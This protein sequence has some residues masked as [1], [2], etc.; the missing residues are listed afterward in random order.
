MNNSNKTLLNTLSFVALAIIALLILL[1]NIL[2]LLGVTIGGPVINA[3]ETVKNILILIVIGI[4]AY[5]FTVGKAKW[6]KILFWISVLIFVV[7]TV[8]IW[9]F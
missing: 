5:N 6:I 8:F 7:G 4:C 9:V 1:C 3:L 2:P